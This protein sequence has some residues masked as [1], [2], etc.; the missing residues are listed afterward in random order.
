VSEFPARAF[1]PDHWLG[2]TLDAGYQ[3]N[4]PLVP[5]RLK[6][7]AE[8]DYPRKWISVEPYLPVHA[9]WYE[10]WLD[11]IS[12]PK[13]WK[14]VQWVVFGLRTNPTTKL[15]AHDKDELWKLWSMLRD[16]GKAI[17]VKDSIVSQMSGTRQ[18]M[19]PREFPSGVRLATKQ[20]AW[21]PK[22]KKQ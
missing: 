22:V 15:T 5:D 21:K 16:Q 2:T 4:A 17:F 19:A 8:L 7:I 20:A 9:P 12:M 6:A 1:G 13:Q 10:T 3:S 14:D 18:L 11:N